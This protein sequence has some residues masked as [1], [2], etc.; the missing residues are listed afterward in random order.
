MAASGAVFQKPVAG[1]LKT[2]IRSSGKAHA[3]SKSAAYQVYV[4]ICEE[5][6]TPHG[7]LRRRFSKACCRVF[8]NKHQVVR[9]GARDFEKRSISSICEHLRRACNAAW[10][11]QVSFLNTLLGATRHIYAIGGH[12]LLQWI[13]KFNDPAVG[14]GK[15]SREPFKKRIFR[16]IV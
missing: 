7:G 11:P 5:R 14:S 15:N 13:V 4:S 2:S 12:S 9:Q 10:R 6:A 1:C 16:W 3:I 8:K